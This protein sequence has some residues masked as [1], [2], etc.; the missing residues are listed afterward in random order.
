MIG[1]I[2]KGGSFSSETSYE[3][4]NKKN[5]SHKFEKK[6]E[7][8]N[9]QT[10]IDLEAKKEAKAESK[11]DSNSE[12]NSLKLKT[13]K[14]ETKATE[15]KKS[16]SGVPPFRDGERH[17]ILATNVAAETPQEFA[18]FFKAV[19]E[20]NPNTLKPVVKISISA[21]KKDEVTP[22]QWIEIG[23]DALK[24]LGYENSPFLIVQHRDREQDHV[25][26]LTSKITILGETVDDSNDKH[27]LENV[28]R[29]TE[30]KY[31]FYKTKS[32]QDTLRSAPS[33]RELEI[34]NKTGEIPLK[35]R[36]QVKVDSALKESKTV[37]EFVDALQNR[38]VSVLSFVNKKDEAKGI[39]FY[40]D[41]EKPMSGSSLGN[42]FKWGGLQKRGLEYQPTQDLQ[43]LKDATAECEE[44][45]R[46]YSKAVKNSE[47]VNRSQAFNSDNQSRN[48]I[49]D[50]VTNEN[51]NN[52]EDTFDFLNNNSRALDQYD[53]EKSL[54]D[55]EFLQ[56][57]NKYFEENVIQPGKD[58][59]AKQIQTNS[60]AIDFPIEN[61]GVESDQYSLN[62]IYN[63]L[64]T[65]N[66]NPFDA[67][68]KTTDSL[69]SDSPENHTEKSGNGLERLSS[70]VE[71]YFSDET[72]ES[73]METP[74][75]Q[76]EDKELEAFDEYDFENMNEAEREYYQELGYG[77]GGKSI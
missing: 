11:N 57:Q 45:M 66:I 43:I 2:S 42:G 35:I 40:I 21:D 18:Q 73:F 28:M 26:L 27:K 37:P 9:K 4:K 13:E 15:L 47:V 70:I 44:K 34:Y 64:A 5:K 63:S 61:N 56:S 46:G 1:N 17:R 25:H 16:E 76:E 52:A 49:S 39:S 38:G 72:E 51:L 22:E 65:Q 24:E 62:S 6:E 8:I 20:Q 7:E 19:A 41:G 67:L 59:A 53:Y 69:Y 12:R 55:L 23:K 60:Q 36:L 68:Q 77:I 31:D 30:E 75:E 54:R 48:Q 10:Q 58:I 33:R 71:T 3:M 29:K 50:E 32:S 14:L 74:I